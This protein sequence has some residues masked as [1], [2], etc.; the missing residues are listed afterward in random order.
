MVSGDACFIKEYEG[1]TLIAVVDGL[2]HGPRAALVAQET[3]R[4]LEEHYREG[5]TKLML[6]CHGALMGTRGVVM[7][8]A[9]IDH[10]R[11]I[12]TYAG[13]G[14][15]RIRV[16]GAGRVSFGSMNGIV[17][18]NVRKVMEEETAFGPGDLVIMYTDG[19]SDKFGLGDYPGLIRKE[20]QQIA[21]TIFRDY[22]RQ[23]DD[24]LIVVAR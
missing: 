13:F 1:Q 7:G 24:A 6:G 2:G 4:Y 21:D 14:N 3:V 8:L 16:V 9:L 5:L 10:Q 23:N 15:I 22:A 17:G 20:P 12:L 19:I 18:D 11:S